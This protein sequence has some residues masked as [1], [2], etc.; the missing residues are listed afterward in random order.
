[1]DPFA[2]R[3]AAQREKAENPEKF[4]EA[5]AALEQSPAAKAPA[6]PMD[7]FAARLAK[8][9]EK[10]ENPEKFAEAQAALEKAPAAKAPEAPRS[11]PRAASTASKVNVPCS[12]GV[13]LSALA[14]VPR[15]RQLS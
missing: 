7:P 3:L 11:P 9:R 5:Q 1:M 10:A 15:L 13:Q 6:A 14:D 12:V 8:Q 2:A 4:A